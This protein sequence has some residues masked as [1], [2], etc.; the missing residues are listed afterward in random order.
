MSTWREIMAAADAAKIAMSADRAT[1]EGKFAVLL[2]EHPR[3]GM[4]FFKRG[5]AYEALK[6]DALAASDF[7]RAM[8]LFPM[9]E[10]KSRAKE[11]LD[12]VKR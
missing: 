8:A 4:I 10:W 7:Q 12:R 2:R 5:E 1:G 6:E 3:D 9:P 11:A